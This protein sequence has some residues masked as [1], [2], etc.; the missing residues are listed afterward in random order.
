MSSTLALYKRFTR[1]P[2]GSAIISMAL[3]FRA[4]YFSTIHPRITQLRPGYCSVEIKE[5]RSIRNHIGTIH[6]GA[7]CTLSELV[8]GLAVDATLPSSL[9]WIPKGMTVQYIKKAKG[10]LVGECSVAPGVLTAGDI[11]IPLQIKDEK[12]ETVL[13]AVIVFHISERKVTN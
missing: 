4:P 7:L 1:Y 2:F 5:R 9:R 8:G 3:G 11:S 10:K 12:E 6:A 13:N